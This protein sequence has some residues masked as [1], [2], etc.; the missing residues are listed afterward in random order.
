MTRVIALGMSTGGV[1]AIEVL[2]RGLD[3]QTP[4]IVMVQHMPERFTAA[5]AARLDDLFDMD[6]REATHGDLVREG[7]VLIAPGGRH[8][9]LRRGHAGYEVT[10]SDAAPVN[11]H[12]PSV[13]VLF[14]SVARCAGP[15]A[16]GIIMTGMG[17]D[18]ACGLLE[19]RRTGAYTAAQDEA[20]CVV[21]GMPAAAAQL[22]S[23]DHI[24]PLP[25]LADWIR[26]ALTLPM[27][28]SR[29]QPV[30]TG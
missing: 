26:H 13:D 23:A 21:Y 28:S 20:S 10:I 17:S 4:G 15:Q 2:L 3:R 5:L 29:P 22:G 25:D 27:R 16:L 1:Q 8:M 6:V 12:R 14:A 24:V 11:H 19:M 30:T 7:T 9:E 18:G